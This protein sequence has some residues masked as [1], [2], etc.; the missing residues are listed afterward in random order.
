MISDNSPIVG[1]FFAT[2]S[3]PNSFATN[4]M[5]FI[6]N[7]AGSAIRV[8]KNLEI[9]ALIASATLPVSGP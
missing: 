6:N 9:A 8:A 2:S 4:P 7:P 3:N 5:S 1:K